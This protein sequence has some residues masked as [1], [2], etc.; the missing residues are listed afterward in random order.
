[1]QVGEYTHV[2][3]AWLVGPTKNWSM[4]KMVE[5]AAQVRVM[6]AKEESPEGAV[7]YRTGVVPPEK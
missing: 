5:G 1:M 7:Q 2:P 4:E 3:N 6:L